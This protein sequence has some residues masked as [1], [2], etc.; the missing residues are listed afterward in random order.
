M[1]G[2]HSVSTMKAG[3]PIPGPLEVDQIFSP[4]TID[5]GQRRLPASRPRVAVRVT[6]V[7]VSAC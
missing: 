2:R 4:R 1:L 6:L 3:S 5:P 7:Q